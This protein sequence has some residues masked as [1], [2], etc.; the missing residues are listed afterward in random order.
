MGQNTG[1]AVGCERVVELRLFR[2]RVDL[3]DIVQKKSA[4]VVGRGA[5]PID[6]NVL[7]GILPIVRPEP[8]QIPLIGDDVKEF[9]LLEEAGDGGIALVSLPACLDGDRYEVF[10]GKSEA[11][12]NVSNCVS[13]PVRRNHVDRI[14]LPEVEGLGVV[15]GREIGLGSVV[16][17]SNV[18]NR[19]QVAID[20]RIGKLG[21]FGS[22]VA[23]LGGGNRRPPGNEE[24]KHRQKGK[25]RAES[26]GGQQIPNQH[27]NAK[28]SEYHGQD[29]S[30]PLAGQVGV[31]H[32]EG[33][34]DGHHCH[35]NGYQEDECSAGDS[36]H[37]PFLT[38]TGFRN[39]QVF[40]DF[41]KALALADGINMDGTVSDQEGD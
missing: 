27:R 6:V 12:K 2:E 35:D 24:K 41:F 20:R 31:I 4:R 18:M 21:I 10:A 1:C 38:E 36:F 16:E 25:A 14:E 26:F 34:P 7:R 13:H 8:D 30:E 40:S 9:V 17:V 11:Q 32:G 22:P 19:H 29:Y 28:Q 39:N 5:G 3:S 33:A 37:D 15:A 23:I